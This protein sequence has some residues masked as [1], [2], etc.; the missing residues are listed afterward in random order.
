MNPIARKMQRPIVSITLDAHMDPTVEEIRFKAAELIL[1][2]LALVK[3]K[4]MKKA[5]ARLTELNSLFRDFQDLKNN[6]KNYNMSVSESM[7]LLK[8]TAHTTKVSVTELNGALYTLQQMSKGGSQSQQELQRQFRERWGQLESQ[9]VDE[10]AAMASALQATGVFFDN[11]QLAGS[12]A[13]TTFS[14][15][16]GAEDKH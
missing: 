4:E 2:V 10:K 12:F 3:K 8:L 13:S 5:M 7:E 15:A 6:I 11:P 9:G 16:M 14:G 1:R